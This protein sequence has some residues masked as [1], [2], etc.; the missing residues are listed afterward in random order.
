LLVSVIGELELRQKVKDTQRADP[1]DLA[2]SNVRKQLF[3]A[4]QSTAISLYALYSQ[5]IGINAR[6]IVSNVRIKV[7][8]NA[9]VM[10]VWLLYFSARA[11]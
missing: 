6:F 3:D 1:V 4:K 11:T 5:Y 10:L 7:S 9:C 8:L 2:V